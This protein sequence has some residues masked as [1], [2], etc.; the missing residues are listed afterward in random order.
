MVP[1]VL[2]IRREGIGDFASASTARA[3]KVFAPTGG[4]V[5]LFR[6]LFGVGAGNP[7]SVHASGEPVQEK[8]RFSV[9]FIVESGHPDTVTDSVEFAT[10]H[11]LV[12]V[13]STCVGEAIVGEDALVVAVL[14]P[15]LL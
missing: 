11:A 9:K 10:L 4:V 5:V 1:S 13:A 2:F 12:L 7:T 8:F 14:P 6:F 3:K 15:T